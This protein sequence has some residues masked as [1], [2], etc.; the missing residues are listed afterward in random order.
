[1]TVSS[2]PRGEHTPKPGALTRQQREVLKLVANGHTSAR[3]GRRLGVEP[4]SVTRYLTGIYRALGAR[5]RAHAVAIAL[6]VGELD[7]ADIHLPAFAR[8]PL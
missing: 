5:D 6:T 3:I 1:M 7:S 4:Q 2:S 8:R